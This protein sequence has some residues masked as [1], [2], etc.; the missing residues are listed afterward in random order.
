MKTWEKS[1]GGALTFID[2]SPSN[3]NSLDNFKRKAKIDIIF[4]I[5]DHG[6]KESFDG[7]GGLIAH[8]GYP[9]NGI[10]HFDASEKWTISDNDT[11]DYVDLRYVCFKKFNFKW[12]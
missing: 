3:R 1:A 7:P 12:K 11:D 2:L 8:S 4:A 10:I 9:H 6:D 5:Y